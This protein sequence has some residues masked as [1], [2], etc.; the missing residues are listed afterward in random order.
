MANKVR[1]NWIDSWMWYTMV[2]VGGNIASNTG[3]KYG[4]LHF[5]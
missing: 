3:G 5:S 2:N 1:G 4:L